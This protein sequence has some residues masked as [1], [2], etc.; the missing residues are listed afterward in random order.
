MDDVQYEQCHVRGSEGK[1][2]DDKTVDMGTVLRRCSG[3][4]VKQTT[5]GDGLG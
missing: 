1:E 5:L 3:V 4:M 2:N